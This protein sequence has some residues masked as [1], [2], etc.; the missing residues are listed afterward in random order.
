MGFYSFIVIPAQSIA[1]TTAVLLGLGIFTAGAILGAWLAGF[2]TQTIYEVGVDKGDYI[3]NVGVEWSADWNNTKVMLTNDV[4]LLN[5]TL[6]YYWFRRAEAMAQQFINETTFPKQKVFEKSLI[7]EE[8]LNYS[9]AKLDSVD[10]LAGAFNSFTRDTLGAFSTLS[11]KWF[12][13][14]TTYPD[15]ADED[16]LTPYYTGVI[17]SS[18]V[19][20]TSIGQFFYSDILKDGLCHTNEYAY[21]D[22]TAG[23]GGTNVLTLNF[24]EVYD[25]GT[26][27]SEVTAQSNVTSQAYT[28]GKYNMNWTMTDVYDDLTD[29]QL[30][31]VKADPQ[32]VL[33]SS[34]N[35]MLPLCFIPVNE[36]DPD[37]RYDWRIRKMYDSPSADTNPAWRL[38]KIYWCNSTDTSDL[39]YTTSFTDWG[40]IPISE[41]SDL[42]ELLSN[43]AEDALI[44]G[45]TYWN[46]LRTLGYT[47]YD[48]LPASYVIPAPS[49]VY[50]GSDVTDA[51]TPEQMF[52]LYV[53]YMNGMADFFTSDDYRDADV[54]AVD[55][56]LGD[57]TYVYN[58]S[59][60]ENATVAHFEHKQCI[61]MPKITDFT[62]TVCENKTT[63][64]VMDIVTFTP[65][66]ETNA[67]YT[68]EYW[69]IDAD[70]KIHVF[71]VYLD[72]EWQNVTS[73]TIYNKNLGQIAFTYDFT[74]EGDP[75]YARTSNYGWIVALMI[76]LALL[77]FV[78]SMFGSKRRRNNK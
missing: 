57:L 65:T 26:V 74:L 20:E 51:L 63:G 58:A 54:G 1:V 48:E 4:A 6:K 8:Y 77:G 64:Q 42:T 29:E 71:D 10:N 70:D 75:V 69:A 45:Q 21:A 11:V 38:T 23:A 67:T 55:I 34:A 35:I 36:A 17:S 46:Y 73:G 30:Y 33:F 53:A 28:S 76:P 41:V 13:G 32:D 72:G 59:C 60:Y 43:Y 68:P 62:F 14:E 31:E 37:H 16:Y 78:M 40:D 19:D 66:T 5:T 2:F 52:A 25:N 7:K 22:A 56:E 39:E 61:I 44:A 49:V 50:L 27:A 12:Y 24:Y 3:Y 9:M 15:F 47:D 18:W